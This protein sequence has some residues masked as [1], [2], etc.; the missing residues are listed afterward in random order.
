[1]SDREL[2]NNSVEF[3]KIKIKHRDDAEYSGENCSC[4]VLALILLSKDVED[5]LLCDALMGQIT[6]WLTAMY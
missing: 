3:K 2:L 6:L 4:H 1:M 5:C